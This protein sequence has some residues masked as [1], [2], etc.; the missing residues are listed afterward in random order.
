L[1]VLGLA[2][3]VPLIVGGAALIMA[4]LDRLP[5]LIWAGAALLGW[6]AGDVIATDPALHPK[7]QSLFAGWF[8]ASFDAFLAW[9]GITTRTIGA[10]GAEIAFAVLGVIVV[11]VAGS[12]WRRRKLQRGNHAAS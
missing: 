3:S 10:A 1:L 7:L 4:L 8:G 11:L 9:L 5:F 2:I 6:I 12:I